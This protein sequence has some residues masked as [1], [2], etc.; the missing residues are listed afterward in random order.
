MSKNNGLLI[1]YDFCTGCHSCEIACQQENNYPPGKCG[2]KITEYVMPGRQTVAVVYLPF[3]T[4]WC[5]L[6]A[7]R[8]HAGQEPACVHH[9]QAQVIRYGPISELVKEMEKKPKTA[10]FKPL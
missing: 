4:E 7:R 5:V 9:C 6:C 1:D 2:M 10:L 8:T 3:P